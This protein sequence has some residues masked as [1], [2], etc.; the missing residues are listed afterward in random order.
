[1]INSIGNLYQNKIK[2]INILYQSKYMYIF[3]LLLQPN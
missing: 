1:M 3:S 2:Y